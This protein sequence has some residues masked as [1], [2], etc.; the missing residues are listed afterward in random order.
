MAEGYTISEVAAKVKNDFGSIDIL[1]S[2]MQNPI[3]NRELA[4]KQPVPMCIRL[5][6]R[7]EFML[8]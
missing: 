6:F 4:I 3:T 1:V 5:S 8:S 2:F 7:F